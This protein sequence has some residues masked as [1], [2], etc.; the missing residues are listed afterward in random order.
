MFFKITALELLNQGKE[1]FYTVMKIKRV[2]SYFIV[3][4]IISNIFSGKVLSKNREEPL[5]K[6]HVDARCAVALDSN[7]KILMYE[8]NAYELVPM[9]STT[10]VM[11][12]LVALRYGKLDKK[13]KISSRAAGI[14]GST[15]GYRAGEEITLRELLYGLMLRSGNDAAVAIAE[16]VG[17]NIE[18]FAKL[19]NEYADEI[20]IINSHF[21]TPHG[22]DKDEHYSTAYDLAV[23]TSVAKKN[24]VFNEIVGSRDV[25]GK[26]KGFTMSYHNINKI[27]WKIPDANGVKTGYTG[28]AGKCLITSAPVQGNDV[29]IV[30]LNCPERWK[31]T[32]K[33]YN[34]ISTTY[35]FQKLYSKGDIALKIKV[36]GKNLNLEYGN[37]IVIPLK[38]GHKYTTKILKPARINYTVKKGDKVGMICIYEDG[39][40]IYKNSLTAANTV[41]VRRFMNWSF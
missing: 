27:L 6:V 40:N 3:F 31:E 29:I 41:K 34:Y 22:L 9:A 5:E 17:G 10:K 24:P 36:N 35:N 38:K 32:E 30:V 14:K 37:D 28:K 11:T 7:S 16:G 19:M 25:D 33:I 13:I 26:E 12:T 1:Q 39:R 4:F 18:K 8:K 15:V 23:A 21:E 2:L 20:G